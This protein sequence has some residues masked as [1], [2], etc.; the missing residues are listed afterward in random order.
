MVL[1]WAHYLF[2]CDKAPS[3]HDLSQ[4]GCTV[5]L[6]YTVIFYFHAIFLEPWVYLDIRKQC[7]VYVLSS[8]TVLVHI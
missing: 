2:G 8:F 1:E 5:V 4:G 3:N 6:F 7:T